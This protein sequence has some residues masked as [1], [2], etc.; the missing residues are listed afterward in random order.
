MPY[1]EM[2]YNEV[3]SVDHFGFCDKCIERIVIIHGYVKTDKV[4]AILENKDKEYTKKDVL[5]FLNERKKEEL[6]NRYYLKKQEE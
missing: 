3:L 2:C 1:C 6:E 5:K 4:I